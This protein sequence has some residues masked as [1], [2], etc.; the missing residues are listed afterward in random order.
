[1]S[2]LLGQLGEMSFK[3][4]RKYVFL[5]HLNEDRGNADTG[6]AEEQWKLEHHWTEKKN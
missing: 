3:I 4:T 6:E 1:M 2:F 5:I